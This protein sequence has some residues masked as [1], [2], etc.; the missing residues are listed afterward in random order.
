MQN[1][2][3]N[4][5]IITDENE[6]EYLEEFKKTLSPQIKEALIKR[7]SYLVKHRVDILKPSIMEG[8]FKRLDY[9]DLIFFGYL[10]LADAIDNYNLNRNVIFT[11]YATTRI[12]EAIYDELRKID[13][14][15]KRIRREI[16]TINNAREILEIKLKGSPTPE[17]IEE[18][19][20]RLIYKK[21]NPEYLIEKKE[22][23]EE[24][25]NALKKLPKK[26]HDVLKLYDYE[27]LT[28]KEIGKILEVPERK[29]GQ[30]YGKALEDLRQIMKK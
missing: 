18:I 29:V 24:I 15:S 13:I 14:L 7:Y 5:I 23:R 17:E 20:S 28:V 22:V 27:G 21:I 19:I 1:N 6:K 4:K 2:L 26:E 8:G 11:D 3:T 9:E 12:E 30:I 10:G 25:I 16:R